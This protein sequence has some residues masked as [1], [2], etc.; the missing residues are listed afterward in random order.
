MLKSNELFFALNLSLWRCRRFI[1]YSYGS[2]SVTVLTGATPTTD[3]NSCTSWGHTARASISPLHRL[4][5][6]QALDFGKIRPWS[7]GEM[8]HRPCNDNHLVNF[9]VNFALL[10]VILTADQ[11]AKVNVEA[12]SRKDA[13]LV[14]LVLG[15]TS[16][17]E[18][19]HESNSLLA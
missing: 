19:G 16:P 13:S 10:K 1:V 11:P 4:L 2:P 6:T 8:K 15:L 17:T 18:T 14:F 9:L 5:S 7:H 12:H 3:P